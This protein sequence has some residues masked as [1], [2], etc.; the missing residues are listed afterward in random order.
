MAAELGQETPQPF[1]CVPPKTMCRVCPAYVPRMGKA[2][3]W[4]QEPRAGP[5]REAGRLT[6]MA[7]HLP[8]C[9]VFTPYVMGLS[10]DTK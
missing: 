3:E 1:S 10:L 6:L 7:D 2:K 8:I 4:R 9:L 5:S